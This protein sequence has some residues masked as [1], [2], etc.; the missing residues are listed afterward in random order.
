MLVAHD[1]ALV[2]RA[3]APAAQAREPGLHYEHAQMGFNYRL[4]NL[5]AA[6]GR[7]QLLELDAKVARRRAV[8]ARYRTRFAG[9]EGIG[10][11]PDAAGGDATNWESL[12]PVV[13]EHGAVAADRAVAEK[14]S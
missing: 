4:S 2:E 12:W 13:A 14:V 10:F 9:V 6:V 7:G 1:E 5:L 3:R 8:N 11:M